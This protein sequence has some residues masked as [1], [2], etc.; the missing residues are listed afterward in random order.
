MSNVRLKIRESYEKVF[1]RRWRDNRHRVSKLMI[2]EPNSKRSKQALRLSR[3]DLRVLIGGLT[4]T[5]PVRKMLEIWRKAP[6]STSCRNCSKE[7]ESTEHWLL[8][9]EKFAMARLRLLDIPIINEVDNSIKEAH[10]GKILRLIKA[11]KF[12]TLFEKPEEGRN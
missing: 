11:T 2:G 10:I 1:K 7:I 3:K 5:A 6:G 4:G 9:C 8:R 12:H